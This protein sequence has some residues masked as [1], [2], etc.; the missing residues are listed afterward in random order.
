MVFRSRKFYVG[1]IALGAVFVIYLL[2][3]R[4]SQ[5]PEIDFNRTAEFTETVSESNVGEFEGEVG[6][7]SKVGVGTVEKARYEH[8]DKKTKKI[9]RVFGFEKLLHEE[10]DEWEIEKPYLNIFQRTFKCYI[11]ANQG[12]VQVE[13]IAGRP[14][15]KDATFT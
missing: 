8:R 9:D 11:T 13:T 3:S 2:Y 5:T 15:P 12:R 6:T 14:T 4:M 1:L 10:G 7:I